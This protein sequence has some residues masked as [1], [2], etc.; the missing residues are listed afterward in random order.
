M[1]VCFHLFI[2]IKRIISVRGTMPVTLF[3]LQTYPQSHSNVQM[4]AQLKTKFALN[5][6]F[7]LSIWERII[8][9]AR[10]TIGGAGITIIV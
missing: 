5:A 1:S 2:T 8:V 10:L 6:N 7:R 9:N 3:V 4:I